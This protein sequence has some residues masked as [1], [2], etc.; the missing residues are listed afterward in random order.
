M[1]QT[2]GARLRPAVGLCH[3]SQGRTPTEARLLLPQKLFRVWIYIR[4]QTHVH[5]LYI[6][7][8]MS[9]YG[10]VLNLQTKANVKHQTTT[11]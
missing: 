7:I 4:L 1:Q 5:I 8:G 3:C 9:E 11:G 10:H 2:H 6:K